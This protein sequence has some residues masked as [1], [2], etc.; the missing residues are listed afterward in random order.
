[1]VTRDKIQLELAGREGRRGGVGERRERN[2][3]ME[4]LI[5]VLCIPRKRTTKL[6]L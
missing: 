3:E 4:H 2:S 6:K 5:F 1:M